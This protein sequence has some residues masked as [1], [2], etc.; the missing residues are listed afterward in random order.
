MRYILIFSLFVFMGCAENGDQNIT[1]SSF[2][3]HWSVY[4]YDS[5][6]SAYKASF[7]IENNSEFKL[8]KD[9]WKI[10]YS[11]VIFH[12]FSSVDQKGITGRNVS[13]DLHV[14]EPNEEW[15]D[16][17]VGE[18]REY[19]YYLNQNLSRISF[20]PKGTFLVVDEDVVWDGNPEIHF[21]EKGYPKH[22]LNQSSFKSPEELYEKFAMLNDVNEEEINPIIPVPK[23][24]YY[25]EEVF[26]ADEIRLW[27]EP[28]LQHEITLFGKQLSETF[29]GPIRIG[30]SKEEANIVVTIN[31]EVKHFEGYQLKISKDRISIE[32]NDLAGA[33]YGTQSLRSL[34]APKSQ[35]INLKGRTIVDYPEFPYRGLHL[36]MA[37]NFKSKKSVL[38]VLEVMAAYKLNKLNLQLTDDEGWRIEIPGLPELTEY[39]SK[40][41]YS[42]NEAT[43]L[44]PAYG[45]GAYGTVGGTGYYSKLDFI[46]I[47]QHAKDLHIE[48]IPKIDLPGHARAAIKAMEYR[49]EKLVKEG[50]Q[51]EAEKYLLSDL[52]DRSDY[53]SI[54]NYKDNVICVCRESTYTFITKVVDE[55]VSMYKE[56]DA[57]LTMVHIGG[58]EVPHNVWSDSPICKDWM[59]KNNTK[60]DKNT[61]FS[62]FIDRTNQIIANQSKI[63]SGWEEI[64]ML[65]EHEK[66]VPNPQFLDKKF[67]PYVWH[68]E[69]VSSLAN[70][71][72]KVVV[73]NSSSV[74]FD[75]AYSGNPKETGLSWAGFV[76]LEEPYMMDVDNLYPDVSNMKLLLSENIMGIQGQLWGETVPDER[77]MYFRLFPKMFSLSEN[78][79]NRNQN[80]SKTID[81]YK[82][83]RNSIASRELPRIMGMNAEFVYHVPEPGAIIQN[84]TL[85]VQAGYPNGTVRYTLN[86]SDP[87]LNSPEIES[88]LLIEPG[89]RL[90]LITTHGPFKSL[91]TE[92]KN[93]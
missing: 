29:E 71:G 73:C 48:V 54:Q 25:S 33:F 64:A 63:T 32:G 26:L 76:G 15:T 5:I 49:Y 65:E 52:E 74:Y 61:L 85:Y 8:K 13:G 92:I 6:K 91:I 82:K 37:R 80:N 36:D 87:D 45:S 28:E 20:A 31:P 77:E 27:G 56:A 67:L 42:K 75:L 59:D 2:K 88:F 24:T 70:A 38:E 86:G 39:G 22:I 30:E 4:E 62:Y 11:Q 83:F 72:F 10:Y 66:L 7:T 16:L 18:K 69:Y 55:I 53:T 58:D 44:Y 68:S 41:G 12:G 43:Q 46:E 89:A 84:D 17:N 90:K 14:L 35:T 79:W 60:Y 78:A 19:V 57:P 3:V 9:N 21:F 50:K 23:E 1:E 93:D 81:K 40:R 51:A 47:L 34:I